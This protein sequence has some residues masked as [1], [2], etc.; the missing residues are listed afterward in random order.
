M[1][2]SYLGDSC[3]DFRVDPRAGA[4]AADGE[5]PGEWRPSN[6]TFHS[7]SGFGSAQVGGV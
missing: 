2:G 6:Q 5:E 3:R 1:E 7:A 4:G